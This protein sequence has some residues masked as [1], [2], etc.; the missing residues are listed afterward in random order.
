VWKDQFAD[1]QIS[2]YGVTNGAIALGLHFYCALVYVADSQV[3]GSFFNVYPTSGPDTLGR[4][5]WTLAASGG[6]GG[7]SANAMCF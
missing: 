3:A 4:Y 5:T 1:K 6:A 7:N 2:Y